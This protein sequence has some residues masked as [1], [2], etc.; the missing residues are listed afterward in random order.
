MQNLRLRA[1]LQRV[2]VEAAAVESWAAGVEVEVGSVVTK[3]GAE[4]TG[5]TAS[6][7]KI[8]VEPS[9]LPAPCRRKKYQSS[10]EKICVEPSPPVNTWESTPCAA[11][12][13]QPSPPP[14]EA[15]MVATY[16]LISRLMVNP[17]ADLR[18]IQEDDPE[19]DGTGEGVP[20]KEAYNMLIQYATMEE[21]LLEISRILEGGCAK[22][23]V[24]CRV[25]NEA[26]WKALDSVCLQ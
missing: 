10:P 6:L 11:T 17:A 22:G 12:K 14:E 19:P 13:C 26:V 5:R 8:E 23:K 24:G 18:T 20:C 7:A 1:L 25:K 9:P 15:S 21:K 3:E 2:G 4:M 16:K